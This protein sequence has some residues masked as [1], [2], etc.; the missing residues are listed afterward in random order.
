MRKK[1]QCE[2]ILKYL[3]TH[4]TGITPLQA[5]NKFGCL[6]LSGRIYDLKDQGYN[7]LTNMVEVKTADGDVSRVAQYR[8]V[9]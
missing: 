1:S 7:I 4:T 6:R 9:R 3:Q 2:L 8:L 5:L